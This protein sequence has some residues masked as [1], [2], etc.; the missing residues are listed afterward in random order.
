M[1]R[2]LTPKYAIDIFETRLVE[3]QFKSV[4]AIDALAWNTRSF[5]RASTENLEKYVLAYGKS[6]EIGGTNEHISKELGYIPYP[7]RAVIRFN[8]AHGATIASWVAPQ[9]MVW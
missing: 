2:I 3:G 6:L 5:G 7:N 4:K 8:H 9:F 1:G